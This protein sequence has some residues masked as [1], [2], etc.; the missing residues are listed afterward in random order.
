MK[1]PRL[2]SAALCV[3]LVFGVPVALAAPEETSGA[4]ATQ[5]EPEPPA[6]PPPADEPSPEP[7]SEP[8]PP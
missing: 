8:E 2:A 7:P 4:T 6:E 3:A 1:L 5:T